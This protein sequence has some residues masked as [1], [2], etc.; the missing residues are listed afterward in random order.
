MGRIQWY[1]SPSLGPLLS[2][3]S[4]QLRTH[5]SHR[6]RS[7]LRPRLSRAFR[8]NQ[9]HD[10]RWR[11]GHCRIFG[12]RPHPKKLYVLKCTTS[13]AASGRGFTW[14]GHINAAPRGWWRGRQTLRIDTI[15]QYYGTFHGFSRSCFTSDIPNRFPVGGWH[16][17][18]RT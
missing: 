9:N 2:H 8:E 15:C 3:N 10:E 11:T 1:P 5:I 14:S 4:H 18:R 17:S 13:S 7:R 6:H 16:S 12:S